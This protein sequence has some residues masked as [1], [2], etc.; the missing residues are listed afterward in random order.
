M[1]V[2]G[3]FDELVKSP[4]VRHSGESR[5]PEPIGKTGFRLSSTLH[6]IAADGPE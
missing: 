2:S 1:N 6:S 3:N 4:K 5:S